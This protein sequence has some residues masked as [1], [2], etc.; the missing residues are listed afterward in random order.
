M[1]VFRRG[2]RVQRDN[3]TLRVK[4]VQRDVVGVLPDRVVRVEVVGQNLAAEAAQMADD[5]LADLARTDDT[6]R[7][8]GNIAAHLAGQRV[9]LHVSAQ[10]DF[11]HAAGTHQHEHD[12]I[13]GHAVRRVMAVAD[14]QTQLFGGVQRDMIIADAAAGQIFDA[15]FSPCLQI[16]R[17]YLAG[18]R[19]DGVAAL[20]Q[21]QVIR[22]RHVG[23]AGVVDAVAGFVGLAVLLLIKGTQRVKHDFHALSSPVT[24]E[25]QRFRPASPCRGP[26]RRC[27][28]CWGC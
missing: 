12:R 2:V 26:P 1:V 10:H 18:V 19:A 28:A 7:A 15:H 11:V 17:A 22:A 25:N 8:A 23:R 20:G 21:M 9:V 16:F 4:L 13:V 3:V 27:C 14:A 5:R 24:G 6:H